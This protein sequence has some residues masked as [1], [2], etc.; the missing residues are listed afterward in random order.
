MTVLVLCDQAGHKSGFGDF[1]VSN[2][3]SK[4]VLFKQRTLN[5]HFG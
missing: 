1:L 2:E 5:L 3:E 4:M